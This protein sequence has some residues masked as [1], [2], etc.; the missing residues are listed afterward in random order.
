MS[1]T[2]GYRA[3][4]T[5]YTTYG[6]WDEPWDQATAPKTDRNRQKGAERRAAREAELGPRGADV[7]TPLT[8]EQYQ[9]NE[10]CPGCGLP[11]RGDSE[12]TWLNKPLNA[13]TEDER[14]ARDAEDA[15]YSAAHPNHQAARWRAG[16]VDPCSRCCPAPP[17]H[18]ARLAELR[19]DPVIQAFY[20]NEPRYDVMR[21]EV[22]WWCGCVTEEHMN[23]DQKAYGHLTDLHARTCTICGADPVVIVGSR[24]LGLVDQP[25][26][27]PS[28]AAPKRP[29][30]QDRRTKAELLAELAE[31]RD[32]VNALEARLGDTHR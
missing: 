7:L 8:W 22:R 27:P 15:R 23:M 26:P 9:A 6:A 3:D 20:S 29:Q 25:P 12:A 13:L 32:R 31:L 5:T 17:M 21:W 10:L 28:K 30:P 18:P 24:A 4:L 1:S 11:V 2:F 19:A 16:N 14:A